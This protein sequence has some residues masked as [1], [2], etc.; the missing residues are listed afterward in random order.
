M[1]LI[2]ISMPLKVSRYRTNS[3]RPWSAATIIAVRL[4]NQ[5]KFHE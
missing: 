1:S 3:T 5:I 4:N 2:L